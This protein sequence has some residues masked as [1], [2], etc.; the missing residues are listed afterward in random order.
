MK[1]IRRILILLGISLASIAFCYVYT[2]A[3]LNAARS[4]GVYNTAEQGMLAFTG[5]NYSENSSVKILLAGP[6]SLVGRQPYYW[7]VV[8]EVHGATRADNSELR[9][10]GCE[11]TSQAFLQTKDGWV[12]VPDLAFPGFV[13]FWMD[14]FNLAGEGQSA[15]STALLGD[16]P[17][18]YCNGAGGIWHGG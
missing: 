17:Y 12:R 6:N 3:Q 15:F 13:G 16:Q 18:R 14:A 7:Y 10:N 2:V 9:H 1:I 11:S 5:K 8:A 4:K